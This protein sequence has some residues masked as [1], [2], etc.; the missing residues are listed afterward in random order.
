MSKSSLA[1]VCLLAAAAATLVNSTGFSQSTPD[2]GGLPSVN[3]APAPVVTGP[4]PT[5][6]SPN[7]PAADGPRPAPLPDKPQIPA[8]GNP[9]QAALPGGT[10]QAPPSQQPASPDAAT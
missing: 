1:M 9:A 6:P 10:A 8:A 5:G 4:S 2:S 3:Q 7:V